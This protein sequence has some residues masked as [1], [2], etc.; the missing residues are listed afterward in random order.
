MYNVFD[1]PVDYPTRCEGA[2]NLLSFMVYA[3]RDAGVRIPSVARRKDPVATT[4]TGF[5]FALVGVKDVFY[6]AEGS[7]RRYG[8][9]DRITRIRPEIKRRMTII[10]R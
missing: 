2:R 4:V 10:M 9:M 3:V 5:F 1:Y 7:D 8:S 6:E